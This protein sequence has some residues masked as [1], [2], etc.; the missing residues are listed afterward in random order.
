MAFRKGKKEKEN[1]AYAPAPEKK[2]KKEK[3][4]KKE[5]KPRIAARDMQRAK[6]EA[7][8]ESR[9]VVFSAA[10][11]DSYDGSVHSFSPA[12]MPEGDGFM[13]GVRSAEPVLSVDDSAAGAAWKS[14]I[15]PV[16]AGCVLLVAFMSLFCMVMD[17]Y[18]VIPFLIPG[19]LVFAGLSFLGLIKPGRTRWIVSAVLA[20]L[21][22]AVLVIFRASVGGGLAYLINQFYDTAEEAQAYMYKRL[23]GSE[24]GD[25]RMGAAWASC[26]IGLLASL[27]PAKYRDSV[28]Y[29]VTAIAMAAFA[30]YGLIPSWICIAVMLAALLVGVCRGSVLPALPLI[31]SV[32]VVFGAVMLIDP[33]ENYSISR[34]DENFRD[35]FAFHSL[36]IQGPDT[37]T[38]D[39]S[40][41]DD[42]DD[43]DTGDLDDDLDDGFADGLRDY[44]AFIAAGLIFL[45]AAAACLLLWNRWRKK[46][47]LLRRGID[48]RDPRE[49][50]TAMFPYSVRW[51]RASGMD[52]PA[53]PFSALIP[54]V[55][56]EL[57]D[58]YAGH[59]SDM[60]LLWREAAYSDHPVDERDRKDMDRFMHETMDV[61]TD[62]WNL[63]EKISRRFR[64]S[65]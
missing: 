56:N 53:G 9:G 45:A 20:V 55:K 26:L 28:F 16:I 39:M 41:L 4:A 34:M 52:M 62:K 35:R 30:Y 61:V 60:Y 11:T 31:L 24:E 51:L 47:A 10:T 32:A 8:A 44:T 54:V 14:G 57:S 64:Y 46:R 37:G 65:L 18:D 1:K 59:Y 15:M 33:G 22:I 49:A 3:R 58:V 21:L 36:L 13:A 23:P 6:N 27:P 38:D 40:G 42:I 5:K 48:S 12:L 43:P 50:V 29:A 63:G 2:A 19:A 7:P 25:V 17:C